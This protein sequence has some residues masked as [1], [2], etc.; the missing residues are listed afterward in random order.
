MQAGARQD[1]IAITETTACA[2]A[3]LQ[4]SHAPLHQLQAKAQTN[5]S[6]DKVSAKLLAL[7]L[8]RDDPDD[9]DDVQRDRQQQKRERGVIR[10]GVVVRRRVVCKG[11][12]ASV[13]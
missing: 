8:L 7:G 12:R 10:R 2:S 6:F 13:R 4:S 5:L 1:S 11:K 9:G 3:K